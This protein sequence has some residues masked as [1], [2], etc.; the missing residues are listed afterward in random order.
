MTV[1]RTYFMLDVADMAR[2]VDFYRKVL[3]PS[4]IR[5]ESGSWSE[6]KVGET[7]VALHASTSPAP[8]ATALAIDV[9]DLRACYD[10]VLRHGGH[11]L[12]GPVIEHNGHLSYE[13][14]DTEGNTF[15]LA[16]A[17]PLP[18]IVNTAPSIVSP[19]SPPT[20]P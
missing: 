20:L 11:V 17:V 4:V 6:L 5:H 3:G 19:E 9:A 18:P 15:T 7:T 16:S 10:A 13:V 14:A 2:A 12:A 8:K 1:T